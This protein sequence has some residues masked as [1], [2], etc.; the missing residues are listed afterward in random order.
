[1]IVDIDEATLRALVPM[2]A[3]IRAVTDAFVAVSAGRMWQPQRLADRVGGT[4]VMAAGDAAGIGTL[5]KTVSIRPS[6]AERGL[7][8]VRASALWVDGT[9]GDASAFI[10][11]SALTALRTGAASGAA[12]QVLAA[13]EAAVLAMVGAGA[14]ALDQIDGVRAVR[15]IRAIRIASRREHS[16]RR[17][18]DAITRTG[19]D[20][21]VTV[22][23]T[24][25]DAVDGADVVCCA[26]PSLTPLFPFAALK[27]RVHIN[28]VGSYRPDMC[29]IGLDVLRAAS[30]VC[31]DQV[32]AACE[33][34]GEIILATTA[35]A[36]DVGS[37]VELGRI[38]EVDPVRIAGTTVF[39]SVG[40]AAQDW[41]VAALA[42]ARIGID[43]PQH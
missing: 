9:S 19:G 20:L 15:D 41:A 31:V 6:Y 8:T 12:T 21:K 10:D 24:P 17:L 16:A 5:V 23:D 4:L 18:A 30:L 37:L 38:Q 29:E 22:H 26:T 1:V 28:A 13:P 14:L 35:G 11:G 40:L 34:A 7:P 39:K 33:E 43:G 3:A 42:V 36:L 32:A 27:D 2:E 25:A